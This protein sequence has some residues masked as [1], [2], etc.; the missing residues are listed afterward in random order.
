MDFISLIWFNV[1]MD[2]T[3]DN[4]Y[5]WVLQIIAINVLRRYLDNDIWIIQLSRNEATE[6]CM[7]WRIQKFWRKTIYHLRPHLSQIRTTKYIPFTRKK[8]IFVKKIWANRTAPPLLNPPLRRMG[9]RPL[10]RQRRRSLSAERLI[11]VAR[12]PNC[13]TNCMRDGHWR[14]SASTLSWFL[15]GR[16]IE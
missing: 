3:A 8:R 16:G 1:Y 14:T 12:P 13:R 9:F 2:R 10:V 15:V 4:N 7:Q 6:R 11:R 5:H